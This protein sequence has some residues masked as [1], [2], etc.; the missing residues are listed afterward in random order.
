MSNDAMGAPDRVL[1]GH[2]EPDDVWRYR[3]LPFDV[4]AGVEQIHL[5]Y[6]YTDR[7]GSNPTITGGNVLDLGLFDER[8][9]EAGSPGFR[10]WSGSEKLEITVASDWATPPYVGGPIG[11]GEWNLLLGPYKV[12]PT[13]GMDFKV[14]I[15]FNAG[16]APQEKEL[17]RSGEPY[18]P[19]M[20]PAVEPGWYR[21]DLHSHTLASDGDSWLPD[22][23]HAAAERGLDF[24]GVTDHNGAS[25]PDPALVPSG[26]GWPVL[27]PGTEVTTYAGH[28]NSWGSSATWFDF[29]DPTA[30]GMQRAFDAALAT[31]ALVSVN[32]PKPYGPEWLFSEVTGNHLVEIWNGPWF[33]LNSAALAYWDQLLRAGERIYAIG[34][35]DTHNIRSVSFDP[36]RLA[37]YGMPTTWVKIDGELTAT[38]ILNALRA[39]RSFVSASPEGPQLILDRDG[40]GLRL[41]VA[42][43]SGSTIS[44]I[45]PEG[46]VLAFAVTNDDSEWRVPWPGDV[47]YVRAHVTAHDGEML[48][49]SNPVWRE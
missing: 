24:L 44:L 20:P 9:I 32:H 1:E 22:A 25:R 12:H 27:V 2:F 19:E 15:W 21:G 47:P 5:R 35:S 45:G 30:E 7:I 37:M 17:L 10:G 40:D 43:A 18:F 48:A 49:V 16:I 38:A 8:G 33:R 13:K 6:S 4:P 11:A 36:L 41:R 26:P 31:G 39:G 29:R 42:R 14:E 28:W 23:V 46:A 3:H 34:G